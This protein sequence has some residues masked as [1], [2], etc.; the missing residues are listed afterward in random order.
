MSSTL[1]EV[2]VAREIVLGS[3]PRLDVEQVA[4]G[5]CLG[6]VLAV[7][8]SSGAAVPPFDSSA[9][10]GFALRHEDVRDAQ[11]SAPVAL[12]LAGESRA[13]RPYAGAVQRGCAV[14][15]STGAVIPDG[16]DAVVPLERAAA[17]NG[18]VEIRE[19]VE[20]GRNV[21]RAGEDIRAGQDVLAA[22]LALGPAELGV[23]AS[24]GHAQVRC[25][26]RPRVAV[27]T[28][29]D[30]LVAPGAELNEGQ[31][32]N[33]NSYAISALARRCGAEPD[34][35]ASV[36]DER[37]QTLAAIEAGLEHSDVLVL[38]GGVSV[39]AHDHV[40]QA[41]AELGV[42][43]RFWGIALKPGKPTWFGEREGKIVFG[44]PG[45]PVSAM[46]TFVLLAAPALRALQGSTRVRHEGSALLAHDYAKRPDRAHALRCRLRAGEHGWE[47]YSDGDTGSH[48][49]TSM[50][51]ADALAMIPTRAELVRA[52][53]RVEIELI[54]ELR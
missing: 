33:S 4:L 14:A 53:E 44:L 52:G 54:S 35:V 38:C 41:L 10:D 15:I 29:G 17:S 20:R 39:G 18:H 9:M 7:D 26:R 30:E 25:A 51:G 28:T 49:L 11:P 21:R 2:D 5:D 8:V 43:E 23:L 16:A 19:E 31:I 32:Y 40:K 3:T 42:R 1:V 6:R 24:L 46:V 48:M 37:A 45:N 34:S 13:G 36:S 50:L 27:I 12:E 22:G 47:A